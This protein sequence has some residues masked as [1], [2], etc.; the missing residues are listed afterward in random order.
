MLQL[1]VLELS[2]EPNGDNWWG[3]SDVVA[4]LP[5]LLQL[6]RLDMYGLT[7]WAAVEA[8]EEAAAAAGTAAAAADAESA[9]A[10]AAASCQQLPA[11]SCAALTASTQLTAL[12]LENCWLPEAAARHMFP[13][14]RLLPFLQVLDITSELSTLWAGSGVGSGEMGHLKALSKLTKL[15]VGGCDWNDDA[16]EEALAQLTG[17]RELRM[18]A[19]SKL[20]AG[21]LACLTARSRL[22]YQAVWGSKISL[23]K[24]NSKDD[25]SDSECDS[26]DEKPEY[27]D[28]TLANK[29][30]FQ[31]VYLEL[32]D[33]CSSSFQGLAMM[34]KHAQEQAAQTAFELSRKKEAFQYHLSHLEA[35]KRELVNTR[36]EL[37]AA[38]QLL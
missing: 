27:Q 14:S 18:T 15:G 8:A 13:A 12:C 6:Q 33:K 4:V 16:A 20:T 31:P 1:R 3:M 7:G 25:N 34:C 10:A 19:A 28:V 5:E 26:D 38:Q 23:S 24:N 37:T 36:Q 35:V 22:S 9:L 29:G 21:G 2:R 32:R 30:C 17:L 11:A